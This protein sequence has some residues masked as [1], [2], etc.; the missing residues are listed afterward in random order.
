MYE[1]ALFHRMS[2]GDGYMKGV[3][4]LAWPSLIQ[5]NVARI[6][7][8]TTSRIGKIVSTPSDFGSL[9]YV[10]TFFFVMHLR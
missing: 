10:K 1:E 3:I 5:F 4:S 2:L 7:P 6:S 8:K 9:N